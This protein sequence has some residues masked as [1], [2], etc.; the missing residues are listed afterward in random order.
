MID[1]LALVDKLGTV[2]LGGLVALIL[3]GS[4]FKIWVWGSVCVEMKA[5]YE[6]RLEEEKA[7]RQRWEDAA[8]TATGRLEMVAKQN[9]A[10][11]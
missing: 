5:D 8:L 4:Y 9:R 3:F 6:R 1:A 2:G 10:T 7:A 11:P